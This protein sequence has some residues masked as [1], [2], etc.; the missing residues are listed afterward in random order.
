MNKNSLTQTLEI[1]GY[2]E[3]ERDKNLG[4]GKLPVR[5]HNLIDEIQELQSMLNS[6]LIVK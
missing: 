3:D 5:T 6:P 1:I 2:E 4:K